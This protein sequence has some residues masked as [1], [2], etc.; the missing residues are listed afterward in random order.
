[1]DRE[2]PLR[3]TLVD[4]PRDVLFCLQRGA[5]ELVSATL[6]DGLNLSLDLSVRVGTQKT[7]EPNFLGPF[8]QGR[9]NDR[10]IYVNSGQAAGQSGS[11]W[12]RRAKVRLG[13][14]SW[15]Q[16]AEALAKPD[17]RLEVRIKGRARDGGPCCASVPL[18]DDGWSVWPSA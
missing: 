18:L 5:G 10:F 4:P 17:A 2:L 8:A 15:S 14:I 13:A 1:M 12:D 11:C 7:G 9:P 16:V 6:P 3:I